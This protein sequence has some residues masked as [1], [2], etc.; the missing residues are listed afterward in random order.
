VRFHVTKHQALRL[1]ERDLSLEN[2]KNVVRYPDSSESLN[3]GRHGGS[4]K[5][6]KKTVDEKTLVVDAKIKRNDCWLATAYYEES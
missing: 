6:F 5:R 2:V 4:L 1:S 3:H